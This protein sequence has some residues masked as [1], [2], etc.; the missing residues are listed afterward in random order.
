M[1]FTQKSLLSI[2][3][4]FGGAFL[5]LLSSIILARYLGVKGIGQY[6]LFIS[7]QTIA[8]TIMAMG[9]GNA[10]IYFI[11][12][13]KNEK[14]KV[15]SNLFSIFSLIA[16]ALVVISI[17][18]IYLFPSY[19]GYIEN[20]AI[21]IFSL[22]VGSL[23]LFNI[24]LPTL[25]VTLD[26]LKIQIVSLFSISFL[27]VGVV[28]LYQTRFFDID[29]VLSITG[30]SNLFSLFLL[31]IFLKKD[32][33]FKLNIDVRLMKDM[34]FYGIKL[35]ATN[36]VFL[37]SSNLVIFL[38]KSLSDN[39]FES[40][41]LFS[42]AIAIANMFVLIPSSIGPLIYSKWSSIEKSDLGFEV[43]KTLR[44]LLFIS[45][46]CV[47]GIYL[48]GGFIL[49]LLY[50]EEFVPAKKA[51]DILSVSLIFTSITIV[52]INLFSSIGKPTITLKV[53]I[54]SLILSG[55]IGFLLIPKHD[56]VGAAISVLIGLIF[57]AIALFFY[58]KKEIDYLSL[59][60][61]VVQKNDFLLLK[62]TLLNRKK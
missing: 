30:F 16:I 20:F 36:L 34:F 55:I 41:G 39:G 24:L 13:K 53:F 7:T 1:N 38:L 60:S 33:S 23:L 44:V 62:R 43:M 26:I 48:F 10:S 12:S 47:I 9:F 52:F 46:I 29:L 40:I 28:L 59:S 5:G 31:L 15:V 21:F 2:V 42:R 8:I 57:N 17:L 35:S 19:F 54:I 14:N 58:A 56:I 27:L 45:F 37:L 32:I 18:S 3:G 51:L 49:L 6:Q 22:G 61:L 4:K 25:Y 11:N 50:G